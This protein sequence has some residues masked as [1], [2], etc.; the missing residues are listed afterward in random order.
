MTI[1]ENSDVAAGGAIYPYHPRAAVGAVVFREHKVLLVLRRQPPAQNQW[2]IP[3]GKIELGETIQQ[4][5]EREVFE[6]TGLTVR[7]GKPVSVVDLVDRDPSGRVRF[8]Y[9]L[10]NLVAEFIEGELIP[11]D[12]ALDARWVAPTEIEN[13]HITK[14]T[15]RLLTETFDFGQRRPHG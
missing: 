6:E 12:D 2:A 7:A 1:P 4:A 5:A 8:H 10:I 15:R 11:N 13:L 3:G 14:S 9:I